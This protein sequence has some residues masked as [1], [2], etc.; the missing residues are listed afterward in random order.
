MALPSDGTTTAPSKGGLFEDVVDVFVRPKELFERY[1]AGNFVKPALVQMIFMLVV[2]LA[3]MS[4][5]AP[6]YEAEMLRGMRQSGQPMPEGAAGMMG[7]MA[8]VTSVV[9]SAIA[10]WLIAIFGGLATWIAAK[11]L[12]AQMG[13][14]QAATIASWSYMPSAILGMLTLAIFGAVSDPTTI[15]GIVDGQLGLGRF[16]DPETT[17]PVLVALLQQI[18]IFAIWGLFITAIGVMVIARKD[19]G[20]GILVAIIRF[21]IASLFTI[22]PALLRG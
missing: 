5:M 14:K 11:I 22:V 13:F 8:K 20:T 17:A 9:G 18:D 12:G 7:T 2:G 16:F 4:L 21:A 19:M 15:R 1:R 10:P 3:A 6:Y